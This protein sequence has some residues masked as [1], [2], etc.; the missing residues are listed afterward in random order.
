[1]TSTS[2]SR[3]AKDVATIAWLESR[4]GFYCRV[5]ETP[6]QHRRCCNHAAVNDTLNL[7]CRQR[8][9]GCVEWILPSGRITLTTREDR[10]TLDDVENHGHDDTRDDSKDGG[11]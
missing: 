11:K 8:D 4:D 3:L 1:M 9:R 2:L 10:D 6:E 7:A 5:I